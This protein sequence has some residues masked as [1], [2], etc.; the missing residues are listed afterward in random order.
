[1]AAAEACLQ[2]LKANLTR[3]IRRAQ[4]H[5]QHSLH[6]SS[7]TGGACA[8]RWSTIYSG[9]ISSSSSPSPLLPHDHPP[10]LSDTTA[11]HIQEMSSSSG[12]CTAGSRTSYKS[13]SLGGSPSSSTLARSYGS[14]NLTSVLFVA[15]PSSRREAPSTEQGSGWVRG[16]KVNFLIGPVETES[17]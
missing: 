5:K 10:I 6:G 11:Q 1:M 8:A 7:R 16:R 3:V 13:G 4:R 17:K 15:R 12:S 2:R 9:P 14:D